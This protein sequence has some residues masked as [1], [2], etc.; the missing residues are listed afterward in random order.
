MWES[1]KKA[2]IITSIFAIL[3]FILKIIVKNAY[4]ARVVYGWFE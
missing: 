3:F 1:L 2:G 4:I